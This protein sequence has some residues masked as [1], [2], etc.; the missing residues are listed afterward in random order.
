MYYLNYSF[1][2]V[3][4]EIIPFEFAK[5]SVN[6][7]DT[8]SAQCT[9][10]K[11]DL[12][13]TIRWYLNGKPVSERDG[14]LTAYLGKKINNLAIDSVQAEHNGE[15]A[16]SATNSAGS[17]NFTAYLHVNGIILLKDIA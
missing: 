13:I 10:T 17:T 9:V 5:E 12:P 14:I 7:G 11:G 2:I 4:P 16:C 3:I 6:A 15:Y 8:I 1:C